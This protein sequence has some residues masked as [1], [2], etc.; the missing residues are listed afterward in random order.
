MSSPLLLPPTVGPQP[1]ELVG[2][3]GKPTALEQG[4]GGLVTGF[5]EVPL[6]GWMFNKAL[7]ETGLVS[8]EQLAGMAEAAH[9]GPIGRV[10]ELIGEWAPQ[11]LGGAA[12]WN[13]GK[14]IALSAVSTIGAEV[15]GGT[16][17]AQAVRQAALSGAAEAVPLVQR[18]LGGP[19]RKQLADT[20]LLASGEATVTGS[21]AILRTAEIIAGNSL[22]GALNATDALAEGKPLIESARQ[23][24]IAFA[25]GAGVEGGLAVGGKLLTPLARSVD[26]G[27]QAARAAKQTQRSTYLAAQTTKLKG[28]IAVADQ[29]AINA[30]SSIN[31]FQALVQQ[32]GVDEAKAW[33]NLPAAQTQLRRA[34]IKGQAARGALEPLE[35]AI[36]HPAEELDLVSGA[37]RGHAPIGEGALGK[38]EAFA[39]RAALMVLKSPRSLGRQLGESF[40]QFMQQTA[41]AEGENMLAAGKVADDVLKV[42]QRLRGLGKQRGAWLHPGRGDKWLLEYADAMEKGGLSGLRR[43][44]ISKG[45]DPAVADD[46]AKT[47]GL[48]QREGIRGM[49]AEAHNALQSVGIAPD[50]LPDSGIP[51]L[52]ADNMSL[53][54]LRVK[55]REAFQRRGDTWEVADQQ[56]SKLVAMRH[57]KNS[58]FTSQDQIG[59]MLP[60]MS[61]K[62]AVEAGFPVIDDPLVALQTYLTGAYRRVAYARRLGPNNEVEK[63]L[64][65]AAR[66]EG[67]DEGLVNAVAD[68]VM[69]RNYGDQGARAVAAAVANTQAAA[70]MTFSVIPNAGQPILTAVTYGAR[71]TLKML[72][73]GGRR[74]EVMPGGGS[75]QDELVASGLTRSIIS[76]WRETHLDPNSRTPMGWV[77]DGVFTV[78]QF[79]RME[80]H[81]RMGGA[82]T[83]LYDT[84]RTLTQLADNRLKGQALLTAGRKLQNVGLNLP[85]VQ[86][87]LKNQMALAGGD[88]DIALAN[89]LNL[90]EGEF[91]KR[92]LWR[93]TQNTQFIPSPSTKPTF[94]NHPV[95]RVMFQ[96][97][98]FA[99]GQA[100]LMRD[101]VLAE[102]AHGNVDPLM[103]MLFLAPP[104]GE[105][106]RFA[107]SGFRSREGNRKLR[108]E[109][110]IERLLA[111]VGAVGGW[112]VVS[113]TVMA[114]RNSRLLGFAVGPTGSDVARL[115]EAMAGK[116]TM[117]RIH[118]QVSSLP[119][120]RATVGLFDTELGKLGRAQVRDFREFVLSQ[121]VADLETE[122]PAITLSDYGRNL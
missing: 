70:R 28:T 82:A 113:D 20:V 22:W 18:M 111:D 79:N 109:D 43:F 9:A 59:K 61:L 17:G 12:L 10:S 44:A 31:A 103:R 36:S 81:N 56:A 57:G 13:I 68:T 30:M 48:T 101:T 69:M 38:A 51:L 77:A 92:V 14:K 98:T 64:K 72:T 94:W 53:P 85:A 33:I 120:Y 107:Q 87:E 7:T 19:L 115:L 93:G 11:L 114:A 16:A 112:G 35:E 106:V 50:P 6:V 95:G 76:G 46:F 74:R 118:K 55:L 89:F 84:V 121:G 105:A 41:V 78:T 21:P 40:G 25:M 62:E 97:K 104:V 100:T 3:T 119:A 99:L 122:L 49:L 34:Q 116:N 39:Q 5:Q 26:K 91:V 75:Y 66:R 108:P 29:D 63:I 24:A 102:A 86:R 8:Q 58:M 71:N 52:L 88:T 80:S 15:L 60:G 32:Y 110:G 42:S 67:A 73:A 65:E 27:L 1:I 2:S 45:H 4:V 23:G 37:I 54:K 83:A 96:F 90:K 47:W 117:D